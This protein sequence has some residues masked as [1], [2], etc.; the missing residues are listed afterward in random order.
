MRHVL[1]VPLTVASVFA[2]RTQTAQSRRL[3]ASQHPVGLVGLVGP[4][5]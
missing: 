5:E 2:L 4:E 3:R 1:P